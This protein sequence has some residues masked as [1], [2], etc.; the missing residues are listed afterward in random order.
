MIVAAGILYF[1]TRID[2]TKWALGL[3]LV[4]GGTF[5]NLS[6]RIFRSPGG[7]QG[8]VVDWISLPYWPTFNIADSSIVIGAATIVWLVWAKI[9]SRSVTK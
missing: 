4:L 5:G 2:S 3:G 6:D 9:P 8:P 1:T 7:L